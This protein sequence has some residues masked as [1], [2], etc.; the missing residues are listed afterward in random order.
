MLHVLA[1]VWSY[2]VNCALAFQIRPSWNTFLLFPLSNVA[3]FVITTVGIRL[4][5]EQLGVHERLAPLT[6][7][8]VAIPFIVTR[9]LLV[10]APEPGKC[11]NAG[12]P[13]TAGGHRT[14]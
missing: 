7:A 5:V 8:R 12:A 4:A 1:M 14:A 2:V 10:G 13:D 6:V 3:N 11:A 9:Y